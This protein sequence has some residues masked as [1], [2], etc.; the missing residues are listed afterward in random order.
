MAEGL[1]G[2]NFSR[3][4]QEELSKPWRRTVVVKLLGRPIGFRNFCN[5]LENMWNFTQGFDVI[6]VENDFFL[7]KLKSDCD[8]E[9]V[10]TWGPWV[11]LGHYLSVQSW[12]E[13]FNCSMGCVQSI[14]AWIRLPGMP[15][16]YYNKK[17]LRFI[18]QMV[19]KVVKID[20]CTEIAERG[21][22]ARIAV[23]VDLTK[24][25]VAQF[26]IDVRVQKVEY[27]CMP[28]ICFNC[29][30]FGHVKDNCPEIVRIDPK[31][32]EAYARARDE[33][34][35]MVVTGDTSM[36]GTGVDG[37]TAEVNVQMEK[38]KISKYGPWMIVGRRGKTI[39][40]QNRGRGNQGH[41]LK[42]DTNFTGS[43][44]HILEDNDR[45]NTVEVGKNPDI[46]ESVKGNDQ[47]NANPN[48]PRERVSKHAKKDYS[49]PDNSKA[50]ET[51]ARQDIWPKN[52]SKTDANRF[53]VTKNNNLL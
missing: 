11:M 17:V 2:I 8:V 12:K 24:P 53:I 13:D 40:T 3:R 49:A 15:I 7:V 37:E 26:L 16:H 48:I 31:V 33:K 38:E 22:F 34:A 19:G 30:K 36:A 14:Q 47:E 18:G 39:P 27:E 50:H 44:F 25:L 21:K 6:D 43:R 41:G 45:G 5:R 10:L 35:R 32:V 20:Y 46:R 51:H 23:E 9:A 1:Q 42:K 4:V 29:G 28:R 52:N